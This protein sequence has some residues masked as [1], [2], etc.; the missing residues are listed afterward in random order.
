[1]LQPANYVKLLKNPTSIAQIPKQLL[2]RS[3]GIGN[4]GGDNFDVD[5]FIDNLQMRNIGVSPNNQTS[6]TNA[7]DIKF[8]ITEPMGVTLVERLKT[9]AENSLEQDENYISTPYLLEITFKGY[10]DFGEEIVGAIKPKY[11]PIKIT[12]LTFR[13]E[14]TGTV[15]KVKAIPFH[16][17]VFSSLVS[18]IPINIQVSAGTVKDIFGGTANTFK[19]EEEK[20]LTR[21]QKR[22]FV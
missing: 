19:F 5:F 18:T 20:I 6:N 12:D 21:R 3:G 10:D 1:M 13:V 15:Y 8:E 4:D 14:S 9:E 22:S 16:Q 2:M 7:V 11:V 17:D